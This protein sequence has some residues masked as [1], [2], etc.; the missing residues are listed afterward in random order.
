MTEKKSAGEVIA[1]NCVHQAGLGAVI[2]AGKAHEAAQLA[3]KE[4]VQ[5]CIDI[6]VAEEKNIDK[7]TFNRVVEIFEKLREAK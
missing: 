6:L 1:E 5:S 4:G 7:K 2:T 3:F